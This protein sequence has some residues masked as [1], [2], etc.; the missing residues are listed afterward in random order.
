MLGAILCILAIFAAPLCA[1]TQEPGPG[2]AQSLDLSSMNIEELMNIRVTSASKKAESLSDAPAA[3]YVISGK[4]IRRGGFSSVPDALRS[5]PGLYVAQQ[6]ANVWVVAARGFS[7]A[8]NDKMLVLVDG[9]IVYSPTF[10]GVLWDVQDPPLEDIDRIEVIRGPGGTLWGANAV[11]GVINIITKD[12]ASTQGPLL[13]TSAGMNEGYA[14]RVRY[15]GKIGEDFAYR[16]YGTGND[17]SPTVNAAGVEN[18]DAWSISQGGARFDWNA[19][20]KDT[21]AFDGQG[22]S[23]R[24]RAVVGTLEP[25]STAIEPVDSNGVVKGG[26]ILGR[27]KHTFND[28][29]ATDL[30]AYC[31]WTNRS[32][33]LF[34][35]SRNL[36]DM[37][38]Q[39]NYSFAG[40][41]TIT[42]GVSVTTTGETWTNNTFTVALVPSQRRDTTYGGLLQYDV[43]IVPDKLRLIAGSKFDHND[44]TGFEYQPQVRVVWT[45][46]K[47]NVFWAA[48]SRAVR[49][50]TQSEFGLRYRVAQINPLP[51]PPT[52]LLYYGQPRVQSETLRAAEFGYRYDWGE[53]VSVDTAIYYNEYQNLIGVGAP[54]APVTN[55]SPLYVDEPDLFTNVGNG[56]THG[57]ELL[58]EYAPVHGW[59][60]KTGIAELRGNSAPGATYPA[61]AST[62]RQQVNVQSR[63]D[64]TQ[65]LHVDA[66]Y[67]YNDAISGMLPPLN[68]VDVGLSTSSIHG[69]TFSVWGRNLQQSRHTDAIPQ[70]LSGGEIRRSVSFKMIWEINTDQGKTSP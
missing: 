69:F 47:H 54:G 62:P 32:E 31:D 53:R 20:R 38:F 40:R 45:P 33:V 5:V 8:S 70:F 52:F 16:I 12:A 37:E 67:Y 22:Y 34:H 4:D 50:P 51:P 49:T 35:E 44:Y 23:G 10:G 24:V 46:W 2:A 28:Q 7:S 27:W 11:N 66:G 42:W 56:Q 14:A 57:L 39:H 15:G 63:F 19:T 17:W 26:H 30:L 68:R 64:L 29:S 61:S 1:E 48:F 6:S 60:L 43:M 55:P 65:N 21:V 25:S 41:Q 18:Y 36:C 59:T 13:A 58:V 9:R 3:I